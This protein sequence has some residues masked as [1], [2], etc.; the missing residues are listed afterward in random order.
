MKEKEPPFKPLKKGHKFKRPNEQGQ[1]PADCIHFNW[2]G[3]HCW[4]DGD[5]ETDATDC[6]VLKGEYCKKYIAS[7]GAI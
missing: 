3:K 7:V 1:V 4:I 2:C 6:S 5:Y